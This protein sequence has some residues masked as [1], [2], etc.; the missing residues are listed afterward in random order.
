MCVFLI[1]TCVRYFQFNFAIFFCS[2]FAVVALSKHP[3]MELRI[4]II[5][6]EQPIFF[7]H[8]GHFQS[9]F[10]LMFFFFFCFVSPL[11]WLPNRFVTE[12]LNFLFLLLRNVKS[13][14]LHVNNVFIDFHNFL[15]LFRVLF[16]KIQKKINKQNKMTNSVVRSWLLFYLL[17]YTFWMLSFC[18]SNSNVLT[19]VISLLFSFRSHWL[20]FH[21]RWTRYYVR[22]NELLFLKIDGPDRR[23]TDDTAFHTFCSYIFHCNANNLPMFYTMR[24]TWNQQPQVMKKKPITVYCSTSSN[25]NQTKA[26]TTRWLTNHQ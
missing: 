18:V 12:I 3:T 6:W 26:N 21:F 4:I 1:S 8:I 16:V 11:E 19:V 10:L 5:Q 9:R 2:F 7:I 25:A 15:F 24:F 13:F 23:A 22:W 17:S 20:F 14:P